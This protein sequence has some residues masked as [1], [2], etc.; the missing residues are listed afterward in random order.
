MH[1]PSENVN[2]YKFSGWQLTLHIKS[3]KCAYPLSKE[4]CIKI[5]SKEMIKNVTTDQGCLS[6]Y[7]L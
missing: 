7:Y 4:P 5:D 2:L 6:Q 1:L 3:Y